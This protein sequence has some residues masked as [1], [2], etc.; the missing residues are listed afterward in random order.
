MKKIIAVLAL[1]V[2]IL[3]LAVPIIGGNK[4]RIM[5]DN[6]VAQMNA[7]APDSAA[8]QTYEQGWF[9]SKAVLK[10]NLSKFLGETATAT[11]SPLIIPLQITLYHGPIV[12]DGRPEIAWFR[13]RVHLD[14]EHEAWIAN[15][16]AV[17]GS[18][19]F[20]TSTFSVGLTGEVTTHEESLPFTLTNGDQVIQV[21]GYKGSGQ[22]RPFGVATYRGGFA[23]V[24]VTQGS[25]VTRIDGAELAFTSQIHN[26]Q[27]AYVVPG[28]ATLVLKKLAMSAGDSTLF[29]ADNLTLISY[30]ALVEGKPAANIGIKL[31]LG[32]GE[33][34]GEVLTDVTTD[35][36]LQQL[37]LTFYEKYMQMLQASSDATVS[38]ME[39]LTLVNQDLLPLGPEIAIKH[40]GF[41]APEGKLTANGYVRIAENAAPNPSNPFAALSL[42]DAQFNLVADKPLLHKLLER[43]TANKVD[44]ENFA[45]GTNPTPDEREAMIKDRTAMQLDMLLLQGYLSDKGETFETKMSYQKGAAVINDK[46]IPLPF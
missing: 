40:V 45:S 20:F 30:L 42:L 10:M 18:G 26:R 24:E 25:E 9:T 6:A 44:E 13:G 3:I 33:V 12:V 7:E 2:V 46:T 16:V 19:P 5:M 14:A 11:D 28:D 29:A 1:L 37:S 36:A 22:Y 41:T 43:S 23:S 15:T 31:T 8:W 27:G 35:I 4:A 21:D 39:L 32:R 34:M 38:G 17:K